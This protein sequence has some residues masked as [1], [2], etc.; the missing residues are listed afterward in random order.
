[1]ADAPLLAQVPMD[2]ACRK[3]GDAGTPVVMA[4]PESPSGLALRD[5]AESL[6]VRIAAHHAERGGTVVSIDRSGGKN[7]RL[8]VVK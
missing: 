8:P 6:A 7:K 2:G 1:M 4:E 5:A 3:A